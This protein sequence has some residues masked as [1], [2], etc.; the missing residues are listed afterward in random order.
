MIILFVTFRPLLEATTRTHIHDWMSCMLWLCVLQYIMIKH[1]TKCHGWISW[2]DFINLDP[3]FD[4]L[5][6]FIWF[7]SNNFIHWSK[8][9]SI[10]YLFYFITLNQLF[11]HSP[12]V[13]GGKRR[14]QSHSGEYD[15]FGPDLTQNIWG[16][17]I[18]IFLV[19]V[20]MLILPGYNHYIVI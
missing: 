14:S 1:M 6:Y 18:P 9:I 13:K 11:S 20:V 15:W 8:L 10:I 4:L 3:W 16:Q 5:S 19:A 12:S 7:D 17:Y 2:L